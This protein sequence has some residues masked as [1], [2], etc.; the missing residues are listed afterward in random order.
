MATAPADP[1][2]TAEPLSQNSVSLYLRMGR[3]AQ[4]G[5]NGKKK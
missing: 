5:K 2:G 1:A 4:A 3:N